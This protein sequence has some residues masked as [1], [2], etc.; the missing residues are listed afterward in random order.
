MSLPSFETKC[1]SQKQIMIDFGHLDEN[2]HQFW[3]IMSVISF[4]MGKI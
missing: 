2:S 3:T 1:Q 4:F